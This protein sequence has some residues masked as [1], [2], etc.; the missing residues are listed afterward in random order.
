[1]AFAQER[2]EEVVDPSLVGDQ[3]SDLS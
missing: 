1:L 3:V 2:P